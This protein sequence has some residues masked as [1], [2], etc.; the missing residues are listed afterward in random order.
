MSGKLGWHGGAN[1]DP[2]LLTHR[3]SGENGTQTGAIPET[4]KRA[5]PLDAMAGIDGI[6]PLAHPIVVEPAERIA[7]IDGSVVPTVG[8]SRR[9]DCNGV[10]VANRDAVD[11]RLIEQYRTDTGISTLPTAF[12]NIPAIAAGT[13]CADTDNDGMPDLWEM[14]KFGNLAQTAQG[15]LNGDGYTNLEE[16]LRGKLPRK[17]Q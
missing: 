12:E 15:D 9:L 14:A 8:A 11:L 3:V 5:T 1:G 16:Y 2:W 13:A 4:W 10:W 6:V 7:A 17:V